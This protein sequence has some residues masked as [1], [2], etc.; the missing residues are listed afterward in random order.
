MHPTFDALATSTPA[1]PT[2]VGSVTNVV[3]SVLSPAD[4]ALLAQAQAVIQTEIDGLAHVSKNMGLAFVAAVDVLARQALGRIVVT[5]MGKSG[6]V[7]RKIAATLSSTGSPAVFLHPAEGTHGDLGLL[8]PQDVVIAISYSGET[9]E[10]SAILPVIKRLGLPLV[11]LTSN[12]QSTL[13][14]AANWVLDVTV[15]QEACPMNLAPTASTTATMALGD[16]LAVALLTTKGFTAEDFALVH[17][18]GALGKRLLY[19]VADVMQTQQLPL[20]LPHTPFMDALL[21]MSDKRL[22]LALIVAPDTGV[23][24]GVLTDG[25]VRRA[26]QRFATPQDIALA[27]VMTAD[28]KTIS[29]QAMAVEALHIMETAKITALV[30]TDE[31]QKPIGVCHLHDL[32]KTGIR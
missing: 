21:T 27:S 22:G 10:L 24:L 13:G 16:A 32:L 18:A 30:I 12:P 7:G 31:V 14:Q 11:A 3:P 29:A 1:I 25:D 17:P 19:K 6:L 23:L 20:V 4:A 5:G 8:M 26:L 2:A 28:P 15:P 9:A